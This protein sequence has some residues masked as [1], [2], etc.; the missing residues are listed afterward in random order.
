MCL[1]SILL[2][3]LAG[4]PAYTS[5]ENRPSQAT[6]EYKISNFRG[7][8]EP[9]KQAVKEAV[10]GSTIIIDEDV[11]HRDN[12]YIILT[13]ELTIKGENGATIFID[14]KGNHQTGPFVYAKGKNDFTITASMKPTNTALHLVIISPLYYIISFRL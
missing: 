8:E 3:I 10:P 7:Y 2:S 13:K 6:R 12:T 11:Y 4:Y 5:L 9:L 14:N 1:L